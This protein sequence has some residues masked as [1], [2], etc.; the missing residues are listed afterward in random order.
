[1]KLKNLAD[2]S[3]LLEAEAKAEA[4]AQAAKEAETKKATQMSAMWSAR[5]QKL[6]ADIKAQRKWQWYLNY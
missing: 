2:L 5:E 4:K 3:I 1:M 6:A